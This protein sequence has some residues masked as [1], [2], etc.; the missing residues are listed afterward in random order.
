MIIKETVML[1]KKKLLLFFVIIALMIVQ[2]QVGVAQAATISVNNTNDSGT[3]SLRDA[4]A[5]TSSGDTI[6]FDPSLYGHTISLASTLTLS[7]NI[8]ID[9]GETNINISGN[10][11]VQVMVVNSDVVASLNGLVIRNGY[12]NSGDEDGS[13]IRNSGTLTITNS[14]ISSN[15]RR[16]TG[17][18]IPGNVTLFDA[19]GGGIYNSGTLIIV[20]STIHDNQVIA[21]AT[22]P[23]AYNQAYG[24]GIY[25]SG[26]GTLTITN[27]TFYANI[28]RAVSDGYTTIA[29]G[30]GINNF[31]ILTISNSTFDNNSSTQVGG[32]IYTGHTA[33]GLLTIT[34]STFSN[35][36]A[37]SGGGIKLNGGI[38]NYANTILANSTGGDCSRFTGTIGTNTRN[39]VETSSGCG[40]PYLTS[41]PSLDALADNGGPTRTMA[42]LAGSPAIDMGDAA[43]CVASPINDLDQR[44]APRSTGATCDIG[45]F[46]SGQYVISGNAGIS[47]VTLGYTNGDDQTSTSNTHGDYYFFIPAGWSGT[48]TPSLEGYTFLPDH[49]DYDNVLSNQTGQ[50]YTAGVSTYTIS[51]SVGVTGSVITYDGGSTTSGTDGNYSFQVTYGWSG[52]VTPSL[53]GC[54][55]TPSSKDYINVTVDQSDQD[56]TAICYIYL[57]SVLK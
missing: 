5:S 32:G 1:A 30:G 11:A 49:I 3:G 55:F 43:T 51:G 2:G 52:T 46:E 21:T 9:G 18:N 23:F 10:N 53:P 27:S 31:N 44:G 40:T 15:R 19:F 48:V 17:T 56:Y 38:M 57:P 36:T 47:G 16:E 28:A 13:G 26:T 39:L 54:T 22:G 20:D 41:D 7:T 33:G 42:L 45:A 12:G 25:N 8:T 50:N 34:N 37:P 14:T 24:G 6:T 4:I 35:N 29:Q